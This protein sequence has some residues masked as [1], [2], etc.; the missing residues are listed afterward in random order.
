MQK[1]HQSSLPVGYLGDEQIHQ[2]DCAREPHGE[3]LPGKTRNEQNRG[4]HNENINGGPEVRLQQDQRDINENGAG[5]WKNRFP[6]IF[7]AKFHA[8]LVAEALKIITAASRHNASV[9]PKRTRS[10][11]SRLGTFT[12]PLAEV[13]AAWRSSWCTRSLNTPPRCS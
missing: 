1:S 11:S 13:L 7:L 9:T 5:C 6:E 3:P 12:H 2:G 4:R 8:G 10:F